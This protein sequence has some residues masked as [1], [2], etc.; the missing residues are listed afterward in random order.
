MEFRYLQPVHLSLWWKCLADIVKHSGHD[1]SSIQKKMNPWLS[2]AL[3]ASWTVDGLGSRTSVCP[4]EGQS[5]QSLRVTVGL[6]FKRPKPTFSVM[7]CWKV[8]FI[9]LLVRFLEWTHGLT[10]VPGITCSI[11]LLV[12]E[13]G[14]LIAGQSNNIQLENIW[15]WRCRHTLKD[16]LKEGEI[17]LKF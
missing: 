13:K 17:V 11:S 16:P 15:L 6:P 8:L 3:S 14:K 12:M 2:L 1:I 10:L 4:G 7:C 5:Q 9:F